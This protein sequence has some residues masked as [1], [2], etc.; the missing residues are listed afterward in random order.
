MISLAPRPDLEALAQ[1]FRA[2]GVVQVS[3]LLV[4]EDAQRLHGCLTGHVP[5][6]IAYYEGGA[7]FL[8]AQQAAELTEEARADLEAEIRRRAARQYQYYYESYPM[9]DAYLQRW[10]E[11]PLLDRYLEF[12]NSPPMVEL[13]RAITGFDEIIKADAQATRYAPGH[14]LRRHD[15][16]SREGETW[17]VAH[18]LNLTPDWEPDWGGY[19]QLYDQSDD[20]WRALKPRFNV[21]NLMRVP[22]PHSVT[23]IAPFA[24]HARYAITG[25]FRSR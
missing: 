16:I 12:L 7:K 24:P 15:D 18:V 4:E 5:W 10:G 1:H 20:V 3:N 14:F 8:R 21:L 13:V 19:L 11:V 6:G 22:Q 17:L 2:E 25:W 23:C 9:L